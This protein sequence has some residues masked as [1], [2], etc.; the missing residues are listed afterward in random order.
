MP[1]RILSLLLVV[2]SLILTSCV[3]LQEGFSPEEHPW[4]LEGNLH[5]ACTDCHAPRTDE[6]ADID[7]NHDAYFADNHKQQAYRNEQVCSMCHQTSFCNNCHATDIELKPSI[8]NQTNN[9]QR[10]PHRGD[11]ISRHRIDG[12][13]DPTS[14]FRCHGNPKSAASCVRCHG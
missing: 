14:C 12:A 13:V 5:P 7:F 1:K 3:A 9:Y 2:T 10:T 4:D 11:Y 8:K 6:L